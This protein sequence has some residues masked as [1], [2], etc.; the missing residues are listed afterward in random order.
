MAPSPVTAPPGASEIESRWR[1]PL[2]LFP[3][4]PADPAGE[5]RG[6]C[7]RCKRRGAFTATPGRTRPVVSCIHCECDPDA[8]HVILRSLVPGAPKPGKAKRVVSEKVVAGPVATSSA[9]ARDGELAALRVKVEAL[10]LNPKLTAQ[11]LRFA[12][13]EAIGYDTDVAL[14]ALGITAASN[15]RR[16]RQE[17][18]KALS[19]AATIKRDSKR[20]S[21]GKTLS[22]AATIKL[23]SSLQQT[24]Q[25]LASGN[26]EL[27]M[28][29]T[30]VLGPTGNT[31]HTDTTQTQALDLLPC[32]ICGEPLDPV[33]VDLG[34]SDH[35]EDLPPGT[36]AEVDQAVTLLAGMLG[37]EII[38]TERVPR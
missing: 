9:L 37:A 10:A 12:L 7:P 14:N 3:D 1:V 26:T 4:D 35:G 31:H 13:L 21:N 22:P 34:Y 11:T 36:T 2:G 33:L 20:R 23:D 19:P 18:A 28:P 25:S 8:V 27:T 32:T 30:L 15:R 17:K 38:R 29:A 24:E 6:P 16:A 5:W